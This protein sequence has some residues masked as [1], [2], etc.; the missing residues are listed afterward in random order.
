MM[1]L[2]QFNIPNISFP[3]VIIFLHDTT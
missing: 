3:I 1:L 2:K